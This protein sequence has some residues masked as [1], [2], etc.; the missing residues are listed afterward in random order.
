MLLNAEPVALGTLY[1]ASPV[2]GGIAR[3]PACLLRMPDDC[4]KEVAPVSSLLLRFLD[5]ANL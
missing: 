2:K 5:D 1:T 3:A 4:G